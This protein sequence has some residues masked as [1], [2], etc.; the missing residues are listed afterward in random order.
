[1]GTWIAI[2]TVVFIVG[3]IMG[4]KP[5]AR[6]TMR[7]NL[8]MAARRVGLQ[9]KLVPC[10]DWIV[11]DTGERGK[12]MIAQYG[13]VIDNAKMMPCDYQIIDGKWRPFTGHYPANFSLDNQAIDLPP[14]IANT[15]KGLS[16]KANFICIYWQ[17]N[18]QLGIKSQLET[19]EKDLILLK[20]QLQA[21]AKLV[22]NS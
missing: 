2:A 1:M 21:Y 4:L 9:P 11:G 17:E 22:Q 19:T 12:G 16:C 20:S 5:S 18:S 14:S 3:S 7:D 8:R 13:L 10:P 6:E 15:V